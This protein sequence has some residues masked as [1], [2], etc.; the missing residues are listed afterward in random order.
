MNRHITSGATLTAM[1][2][3]LSLAP[4]QSAHA[5][6]DDELRDLRQQMAEMLKRMEKLEGRQA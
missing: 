5:G 3:V 4:T 1:A 6:T 2:L